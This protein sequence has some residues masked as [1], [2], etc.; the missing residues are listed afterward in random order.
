MIYSSVNVGISCKQKLGHLFDETYDDFFFL[1]ITMK[2]LH[3]R[4][5]SQNFD[6]LTTRII[7]FVFLRSEITRINHKVFGR[8]SYGVSGDST[9]N[10]DG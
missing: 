8:H 5:R 10:V 9:Y 1:I 3:R 7:N 2:L 6:M 4:L